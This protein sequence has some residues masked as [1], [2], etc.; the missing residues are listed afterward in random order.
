[1]WKKGNR[2]CTPCGDSKK[3]CYFGG[4]NME[5]QTS[6]KRNATIVEDTGDDSIVEVE[7]K[8]RPTPRDRKSV[9]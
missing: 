8:T 5:G 4:R 7:K 1:M 3:G 6:R 9:V 2:K